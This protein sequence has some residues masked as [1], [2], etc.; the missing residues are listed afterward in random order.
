VYPQVYPQD[1]YLLSGPLR[2][3]LDPYRRH[4]DSQL[5]ATLQQATDAF[6]LGG[7]GGSSSGSGSGSVLSLTQ[8]V[9]A[10]GGN[11]SAGQ[12]QVVS[13][14]RAVLSEARVV[15]LDEFSS[16]MDAEASRGALAL[17]RRDLAAKGK[18]VLMICHRLEVGEGRTIIVIVIVIIVVIIVNPLIFRLPSSAM[19]ILHLPAYL[20]ACLYVCLSACPIG[21]VL[22]RRGG[23][24][25]SGGGVG[26]R[27]PAGAGRHARLRLRRAAALGRPVQ[28]N[29]SVGL[30]LVAIVIVTTEARRKKQNNVLLRNILFFLQMRRNQRGKSM[31]LHY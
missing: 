9:T 20:P 27:G 30:V 12:R 6:A 3:S 14:V 10:G 5:N 21:G 4:A 11:L 2:D 31:Y 8:H 19:P 17:L 15:V 13:F 28:R 29:P 26:A 1:H 22:L 24:A 18:A 16:S 25:L 7:A 23:G